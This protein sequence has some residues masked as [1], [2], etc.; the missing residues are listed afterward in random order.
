MVLV[1]EPR[2]CYGNRVPLVPAEL[3]PTEK[4]CCG[5]SPT[6]PPARGLA[7]SASIAREAAV[8]KSVYTAPLSLLPATIGSPRMM[9]KLATMNQRAS[10]AV[11]WLRQSPFPASRRRPSPRRPT[12]NRRGRRARASLGVRRIASCQG[13]NRIL[14]HRWRH[15]VLTILTMDCTTRPVTAVSPRPASPS[16]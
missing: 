3:N 6:E 9:K 7:R 15:P 2:R 4:V 14:I 1:Y 12:P 11:Q 13:W 8:R 5:R 10:T 16:T